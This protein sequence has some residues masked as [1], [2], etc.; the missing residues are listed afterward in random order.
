MSSLPISPSFS[1]SASLFSLSLCLPL[2]LILPGNRYLN[3]LLPLSPL[4]TSSLIPCLSFPYVPTSLHSLSMFS[5]FSSFSFFFP[6]CSLYPHLSLSLHSLPSCGPQCKA[7]VPN[8]STVSS[9]WYLSF[10]FSPSVF[11]DRLHPPLPSF[12]QRG[13]PNH[14]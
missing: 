3:F 8:L 9:S 13:N 7:S 11:D 10:L 14:S 6:P 1:V 12:S 2:F 4:P 5:T